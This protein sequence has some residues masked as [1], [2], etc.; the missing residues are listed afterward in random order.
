[1][2]PKRNRSDRLRAPP[3]LSPQRLRHRNRRDRST[4]LAAACRQ[5]TTLAALHRWAVCP[6][7]ITS[8]TVTDQAPL[9]FEV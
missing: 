4:A 2:Q 8:T 3:P 7:T 5:W 9:E 1:V 6:K